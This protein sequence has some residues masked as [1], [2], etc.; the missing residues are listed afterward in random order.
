MTS[1]LSNEVSYDKQCGFD[2]HPQFLKD[3]PGEIVYQMVTNVIDVKGGGNKRGNLILSNLRVIW[4]EVGNMPY[5]LSIGLDRVISI[6]T[7]EK[8][9]QSKSSLFEI[10]IRCS[11]RTNRSRYHFVFVNKTS[12]KDPF[13]FFTYISKAYEDSKPYREV[14]I[15]TQLVSGNELQLLEREKIIKE[16]PGIYNLAKTEVKSGR[17]YFTNVRVIWV[18]QKNDQFN[19]SVPF[20]VISGFRKKNSK[21]GEVFSISTTQMSGGYSLGFKC[22]NIDEKLDD[23]KRLQ[24]TFSKN[25]YL[26]LPKDLVE[27]QINVEAEDMFD[28]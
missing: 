11:S 10:V 14:L 16:Y 18:S 13:R 8:K 5:N 3:L 17:F 7:K 2:I 26:G 12:N 19:I 25:P 1:V 4:Y 21:F 23:L 6:T 28:R 9:E 22:E 27:L 20:Y 24:E 15:R